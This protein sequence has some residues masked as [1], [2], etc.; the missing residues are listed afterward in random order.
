MELAA[1][2]FINSWGLREGIYL[3]V[4]KALKMPVLFNQTI[5]LQEICL[6]NYHE[7][8]PKCVYMDVQGALF[9][10]VLILKN[11]KQPKYSK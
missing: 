5:Q 1:G 2:I 3:C 11:W 8:C 6:K 4:S 10:T 7:C 9:I